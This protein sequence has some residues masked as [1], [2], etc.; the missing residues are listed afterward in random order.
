MSSYFLGI[1]HSFEFDAFDLAIDYS[2]AELLVIAYTSGWQP[3]DE[4]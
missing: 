3:L 2:A 4:R 1:H